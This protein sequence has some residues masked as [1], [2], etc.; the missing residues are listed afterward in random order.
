MHVHGI[1]NIKTSSHTYSYYSIV[2][3][4]NH[5]V[6]HTTMKCKTE[7]NKWLLPL[8]G[9]QLMLS[10]VLLMNSIIT[11][12]LQLKQMLVQTTPAQNTLSFVIQIA[13]ARSWIRHRR[14][15]SDQVMHHMH[16]ANNNDTNC[17]AVVICKFP[18]SYKC[19]AL[20]TCLL[21]VR[22][23]SGLFHRE[24]NTL[25]DHFEHLIRQLISETPNKKQLTN[26]FCFG[27]ANGNQIILTTRLWAKCI[28]Y[29]EFERFMNVLGI[30]CHLMCLTWCFVGCVDAYNVL[31]CC[32][33][34]PYA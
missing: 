17:A 30:P 23:D 15:Q 7:N 18:C 3:V 33:S 31:S 25:L 29:I 34:A 24:L 9:W 11:W 20:D 1:T 8:M 26:P 27:R 12:V 22:E 32:S 28:E 2:L 4:D 13:G 6:R 10:L 14:H 21:S 5:E 16:V 19:S